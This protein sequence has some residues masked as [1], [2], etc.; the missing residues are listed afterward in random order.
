[1]TTGDIAAGLY[2]RPRVAVGG[3]AG[4]AAAGAAGDRQP[5]ETE[6]LLDLLQR[7]EAATSATEGCQSRADLH[8]LQSGQLRRTLTEQE[9]SENLILRQI[10]SAA[11][12]D[13]R[14]IRKPRDTHRRGDIDDL[15]LRD[16]VQRRI[17][18]L[19]QSGAIEGHRALAEGEMTAGERERASQQLETSA[20]R[21]R[22]AG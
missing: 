17:D 11:E 5:I 15:R 8:H 16:E 10:R 4:R 1:H 9:A 12:L 2:A 20:H 18:L 13:L 7:I 6:G 3:A 22:G 14:R 21:R 19:L